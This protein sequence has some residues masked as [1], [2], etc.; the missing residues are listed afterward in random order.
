MNPPVPRRFLGL[1][2]MAASV[3]LGLGFYFGER[4]YQ[5]AQVSEEDLRASAELNLV[6]DLQR[7]P[8][9]ALDD[10]ALASRRAAVQAELAGQLATEKQAAQRGLAG[11][12]I[13]LIVGLALILGQLRPG[14]RWFSRS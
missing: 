8:T 1:P 3:G 13:A 5:L 4:C 9:P 10:D 11:S 7:E 2:I 12:A 6:L 14:G